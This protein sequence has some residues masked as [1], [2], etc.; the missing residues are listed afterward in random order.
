ML[1]YQLYQSTIVGFTAHKIGIYGFKSLLLERLVVVAGAYKPASLLLQHILVLSSLV[2]AS[3]S[4]SYQL[5]G[6]RQ[7]R[8]VSAMVGLLRNNI[9]AFLDKFTQ[10]FL[11]AV[12]DFKTIKAKKSIKSANSYT[13]RIRQKLGYFD[14][15]IGFIEASMYDT[16]R[17]VYLPLTTHLIFS[18]CSPHTW[19]EGYLRLLKIPVNLFKRNLRPAFDDA[20]SFL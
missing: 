15:F 7:K 12:N 9:W 5:H 17:G 18:S 8:T 20:V 16:H 13:I 19:N 6:K 1:R 10:Q 3:P 11:L 14:D 4:L 2:G